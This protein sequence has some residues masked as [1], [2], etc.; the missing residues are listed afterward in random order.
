MPSILEIGKQRVKSWFSNN[1]PT[2]KN[3]KSNSTAIPQQNNDVNKASSATAKSYE[4]IGT[5]VDERKKLAETDPL[6][7]DIQDF[8][9]PFRRQVSFGQ[10]HIHEPDNG[11]KSND[12]KK[13]SA[14][15]KLPTPVP[16]ANQGMAA[17]QPETPF[18]AAKLPR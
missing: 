4:E 11:V 17:K 9:I 10:S 12:F 3:V 8:A 18:N 5:D 16:P 2:A 14:S 1:P 15:L 6:P 7:S 13:F